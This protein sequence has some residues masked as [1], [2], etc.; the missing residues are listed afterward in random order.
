MMEV[1]MRMVMG[2]FD[3]ED[4]DDGHWMTVVL[5]VSSERQP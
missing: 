5:Q 4:E 3:E 2:N 1:I